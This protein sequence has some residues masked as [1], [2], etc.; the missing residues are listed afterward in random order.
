MKNEKFNASIDRIKSASPLDLAQTLMEIELYEQ[1]T[2]KELFDK[3]NDEFSREEIVNNVVTPVFT[4]MVDGL[5]AHPKFKGMASKSGLSAGRVMR[6][7]QEF[8][9][10]GNI[11]NLMPDAFVEY[12]NETS[13]QQLWGQE[14]RSK[15][16]RE[17]YHNPS[18]MNRYKA[19]KVKENGTKKNLQDEYRGT[20]DITSKKDNPDFRRN[21]PKNNYNA[22]TDHIVPLN[23]VFTQLQNNSGLSNGDIKRIANQDY[24]FALT[25]RL[26]NNSKRDMSNSE[27][28]A[29]QDLLK[30]EGKPYVDLSPEVRA[31]M[32]RMEKDAQKAINESVNSTVIKNLTGQGQA[33]REERKA[34]MENRKKEL[35]RELTPEEV[36]QVDNK[37]A[38]KK[39]M[40][41]HKNNAM[42]AG[43]QSLMYALG[44][45]VLF[46]L[47]PLYYE[48]KDGFIN[49]F[50]EG[51]FAEN[52]GQA[53][54]IRF[55]RVKNYV[56]NQLRELKNLLGSG[57]E[58]LKNFL[59]ALIEG[60]IGMFVG[61]FKQI[62]KVLKEG[63]KVFIQ[64]W[65]ILFGEKS[66]KMSNAQKGD[67]ILKL[68]AGSAVALCGI[69]IDALLENAN[70]PEDFR[71]I[72]SVILTGIASAL[73]F[74]A[75]DK[76]DLF[77]VKKELREK[78][79]KEIFDERIKDIKDAT[80]TLETTVIETL[81]KQ[82]VEFAEITKQIRDAL[83]NEDYQ[84]LST[85]LNKHAQF[86]GIPILYNSIDDIQKNR[87]NLNWDL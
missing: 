20:Q 76:A 85:A 56:W 23:T 55:G 61:I 68:I 8:N 87:N 30:K 84:N 21:D 11:L 51:V 48:I 2:A 16:I 58:M 10:D 64:A 63:V 43:K 24:N 35:G 67:A 86:L 13:Q 14:N 38:T 46:I 66:K 31:N 81:R 42:N 45:A 25:A 12:R 69:G 36:K 77:G 27:F 78:R 26:V 49:G 59:S 70:I 72:A 54:S 71:G 5:L 15:Y 50:K 53:F 79:I 1:E 32:I 60:L 52:Y 57:L 29:Q 44:T 33:D 82:R 83:V 47:K 37:L 34:A 3:I 22:E 40:D 39:A 17:A 74:Y 80:H 6:E 73:V 19:Q 41:I 7:C 9:Y 4:T 65:P 28:I 75:L 62:F 18:E